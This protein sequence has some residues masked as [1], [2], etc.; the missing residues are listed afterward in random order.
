MHS[1][2]RSSWSERVSLRLAYRV[3]GDFGRWN[4]GR[5]VTL[6]DKRAAIGAGWMGLATIAM[7]GVGI[8]ALATGVPLMVAGLFLVLGTCCVLVTVSLSLVA[9][10]GRG[11]EPAATDPVPGEEIVELPEAAT[12]SG[13]PASASEGTPAS[14]SEGT[15][16]SADGVRPVDGDGSAAD[17]T[18]SAD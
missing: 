9:L 8:I 1:N 11:D 12:A 4:P 10:H 13:I 15:S 17:V 7:L 5:M 2:E 18:A 16:A 3:A 14:A 6:A